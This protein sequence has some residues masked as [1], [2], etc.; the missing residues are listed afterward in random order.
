[1]V[2]K[3]DKLS[4]KKPDMLTEREEGIPYMHD[5]WSEMDYFL[6]QFRRNFEDLFAYPRSISVERAPIM[7][8]VDLGDKYEMRF[9]MPGVTK[10]DIDIE[11][12]PN[13]I[14]ISA[15]QKNIEEEEKGKQWIR[16]ESSTSF[17][18]CLEFPEEIKSDDVDAKLS[19]GV[20]T[21]LIP[22]VSP[23]LK[24]KSNKVKIK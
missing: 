15:E 20:L 11:V 2:K 4:V 7:D 12:T 16:R 17:Y 21:I 24:Y 10:D 19:D 18:R 22:K 14:E 13:E 1:M 23:K 3:K 9:E 6:G 5:M 8:F